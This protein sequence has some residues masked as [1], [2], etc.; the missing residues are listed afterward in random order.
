MNYAFA[1]PG[2]GGSTPPA[3]ANTEIQYN[4]ADAFGA[5]SEFAYD[6]ETNTLLLGVSVDGYI[7]SGDN[8]L[9]LQSEFAIT[10]D[11]GFVVTI[12]API[13][14]IKYQGGA[15]ILTDD[16]GTK[17][18]QL[19]I[20]DFNSNTGIDYQTLTTGFVYTIGDMS[21]GVNIDAAGTLLAGTIVMPANPIDGQI[22]E[23]A[24]DQIITNLTVSANT[25]QSIKNALTTLAAGGGF[26]YRYHATNTTWYRR[27]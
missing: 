5:S 13:V 4:N 24:C 21:S 20:E 25:G 10:L 6:V 7:S 9:V 11:S 14:Q 12:E 2:G 16:I 19:I 27:Y 8:A 26:S 17:V 3:G 23:I 1:S 18:N 15:R 22:V